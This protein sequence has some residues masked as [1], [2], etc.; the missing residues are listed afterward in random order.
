ME[1]S[2]YETGFTQKDTLPPAVQGAAPVS[3]ARRASARAR[4]QSR[5]LHYDTVIKYI[6]SKRTLVPHIVGIAR[7]LP[8]VRTVADLF[9]GTTRVAQA[10]KGAGLHVHANDLASYSEVLATT[11]VAADANTVDGERLRAMLA[12]LAA[13]PGKPGYF[14]ETFCERSRYFQ[15]KNG[16]RIDAIREEIDVV[17]DDPV[18]RAILLTALMQGADRVDSTTGLQMAYLKTWAPRSFNDLE[19]RMPALLPGAGTAS[20]LDATEAAR[21]TGEVDLAYI[22]PPYNQHSY[23][24][25]YHIWETLVRNDRPEV[26]GTAC[27]RV[28]CRT[29]KSDYNSR[30]R[31]WDALRELLGTVRARYVLVS[32]NDEGYHA[33]DAL[34]ALLE[35]HWGEATCLAFDFKRYVGAQIGIYNPSGEKVGAVSHVRNTEHLF[36]AGP[37]AREIAQSVTSDRAPLITA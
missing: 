37:N 34:L 22:D 8:D 18:E 12:H 20:R 11:Y 13:L 7:A 26:Y 24:S 17:T 9:T 3:C 4:R 33:A 15:P 10:L 29:T 14:T 23:F 30:R 25:N 35:E 6:G 16:A 19:L 21:Q 31:A 5:A 32:F 27:K 36:L 1:I 28:D 2:V